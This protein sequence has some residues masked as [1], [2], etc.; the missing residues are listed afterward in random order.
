MLFVTQ[1][2]VGSRR[3]HTSATFA[4]TSSPSVG[5][6]PAFLRAA[7]ATQW[8]NLQA[9]LGFDDSGSTGRLDVGAA[10]SAL[11][12]IEGE[13]VGSGLGY[14]YGATLTDTEATLTVT[15]AQLASDNGGAIASALGFSPADGAHRSQTQPPLEQGALSYKMRPPS[16]RVTPRGYT[17]SPTRAVGLPYLSSLPRPYTESPVANNV[18]TIPTP[19]KSTDVGGSKSSSSSMVAAGASPESHLG[20]VAEVA[21]TPFRILGEEYG[22]S[23]G[24]TE[25]K[26][27]LEGNQPHLTYR[28]PGDWSSVQ[29]PGWVGPNQGKPATPHFAYYHHRVFRYGSLRP[30]SATPSEASGIDAATVQELTAKALRNPE[31]ENV[32]KL[33]EATQR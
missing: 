24:S 12:E 30:E 5:S 26:E 31:L 1:V 20:G 21:G 8:D 27:L 25:I 4:P 7:P 9:E 16:T 11:L 33:V 29:N 14:G 10:P 17:R 28:F 3:S 18:S 2:F 13:E 6:T 15:E 19:P 22:E 32:A 23:P